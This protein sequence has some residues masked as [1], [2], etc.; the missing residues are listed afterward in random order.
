MTDII[1]SLIISHNA[2]QSQSFPS[3]S[4][5]ASSCDPFLSTKMST[6]CYP[7]THWRNGKLSVFGPLSRTESIP[8]LSSSRSHQF[9]QSQPQH[10]Y[11][12]FSD[13]FDGFLFRLLSFLR[14]KWLAWRKRLSHK[15]SVSLPLNSASSISNVSAKVDSLL[16]TD[17]RKKD[18][19]LPHVFWHKPQLL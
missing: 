8:F 13:F 11:H 17:S 1:D 10:P 5:S 7:Y 19:G 9:A 12:T 15:F 18:D 3:P 16:F 14:G 4:M 6:L 2:P